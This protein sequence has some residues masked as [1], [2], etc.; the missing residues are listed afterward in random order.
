[1]PESACTFCVWGKGGGEKETRPKKM[2]KMIEQK[3]KK[4]KRW[5][6]WSP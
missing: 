3:Q 2:T 4:K 6:P 5:D 1:M